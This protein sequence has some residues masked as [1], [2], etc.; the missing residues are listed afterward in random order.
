[1]K[2]SGEA[3]ACCTAKGVGDRSGGEGE[4]RRGEASVSNVVG[5]VQG[6]GTLICVIGQVELLIKVVSIGGEG[7]VG[8]ATLALC[9]EES[10]SLIL[11]EIRF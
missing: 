3:R 11:G 10:L 7:S 5:L 4:R 6:D 8:G 1:M 9:G 2:G